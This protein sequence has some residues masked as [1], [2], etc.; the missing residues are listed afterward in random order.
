MQI[1][2]N[3]SLILVRNEPPVQIILQVAEIALKERQRWF[4]SVK[5]IADLDPNDRWTSSFE[6]LDEASSS[7]FRFQNYDARKTNSQIFRFDVYHAVIVLQML[8]S[9]LLKFASLWNWFL[10]GL[11][12][13]SFVRTVNLFRDKFIEIRN[14]RL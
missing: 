7:C 5:T 14:R 11:F 13:S 10:G 9:C 6:S 4:Y 3:R 8:F 12:R 2:I 1:I